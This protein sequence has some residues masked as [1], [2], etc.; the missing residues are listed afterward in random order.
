MLPA[1]SSTAT[2]TAVLGAL[3]ALY[4][5]GQFLGAPVL[6]ALSDRLGRRRVL[7]ASLAATTALY[8]VVALALEAQSLALLMVACFAA[9]VCESN[10]ALA[11]SGVADLAP[12][13]ERSRLFGYVYLASSAAYV[14]GPLVGGKLASAEGYAAPYWAV[15]G[16][17]AL[18]LLFVVVRFAETHAPAARS[19]TRARVTQGLA[20]IARVFGDRRLRVLFAANFLLYLAVFGFFR[21]YPMYIVDE[22]S[23]GVSRESEFVAWVAVPIVVANLG[24]VAWLSHRLTPRVMTIASSLFAGAFMV[25]IVLPSDV[26]AL[27]F[28]LAPAAL[29]VALCL[30]AAAAMISQA[31]SGDEQGRALGANQSVQTLA[32]ALSG[33]GGGLLAAILVK[34]P[35]LACGALAAAAALTLLLAARPSNSAEQRSGHPAIQETEL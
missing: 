5:L 14:V 27:W 12:E 9:G 31:V 7:I 24:L 2:R 26:D 1:S 11:L 13:A 17:L 30:P 4:P 8:V 15:T 25:I 20:D 21:V 16:L 10:V 22:F 32:E 29:G 19:R 35:L 18:T 28:T 3:L 6:G 23:L 34:L 33:L